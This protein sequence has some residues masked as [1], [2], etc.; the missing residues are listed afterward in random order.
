MSAGQ[1]KGGRKTRFRRAAVVAAIVVTVNAA[2]LVGIGFHEASVIDR[3]LASEV[4]DVESRFNDVME[5][6]EH[7]FL[8]FSQL[9]AREI[10]H[11]PDPDAVETFLKE[12]NDSLAAVEGDT[13]DGL[14]LYYRERYLY[15]WDTPYSVYEESGYVATERPWYQA[16]AAARGEVAFT[17]P[18]MSYANNY[19]L[20]TISQMQP[21]GETVFA[22]DIKMGAIQDI[23]SLTS[24]QL[25]RQVMIYDANGTVIG[26]TEE[27]Y[28]GGNLWGTAEDAEAAAD[29]AAQRVAAGGFATDEDR[30]KAEQEAASAQSFASFLGSFAESQTV[31]ASHV[32]MASLLSVD[33]SL[34]Y[35]FAQ[36]RDGYGFLVLVPASTMWGATAAS[37]LVP[38]LLLEF[39][40]VYVIMRVSKNRKSHQLQEAYVQLGQMQRRLEIALAAAQKDAAV[41]ELTGMMNARSFKKEV[42][43]LLKDM[44]EG[45]RGIFIMLDGDRFK[46]VNDTYGHEV[47]D[48]AIKLAAQM[49]VGRIRTVD[50]A[51]R[52]HGDEFAVF[53]SGTDDYNV[54]ES[55]L[56]DVNETLRREALKRGVPAITLSAGAAAAARGDTYAELSRK[57]DEALYRAKETHD[58]SFS[59]DADD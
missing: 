59:R 58:G 5:N 49:I 40:L 13:F 30:E 31:L 27:S 7:S 6:Y 57:A 42:A 46:E 14:Y 47:G 56:E 11:D 51:S 37:W 53:L 54:A 26:S 9:L 4:A 52:L 33:G 39:L 36:E 24:S 43:S 10:E 23:A 8:L 18:Y 15:S 28:L 41:D 2:A 55:L 34:E 45:D 50:V 25:P 3:T 22:Y 19:V 48:E 32:G 29:A 12:A 20:S 21:D 17:P 35:G 16:A 38:L 44:G 1:E